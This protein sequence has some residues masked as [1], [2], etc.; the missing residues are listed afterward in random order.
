M[1][2]INRRNFIKG[3]VASL[4]AVPLA[5]S[6]KRSKSTTTVTGREGSPYNMQAHPVA[7]VYTDEMRESNKTHGFNQGYI[8]V[9]GV[10]PGMLI[11]RNKWGATWFRSKPNMVVIPTPRYAI[12]SDVAYHK[13]RG[14]WE[15]QAVTA[16]LYKVTAPYLKSTIS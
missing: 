16:P 10:E 2:K 5:Y 11:F 9:N 13:G 7:R 12:V 14:C 4:L 15:V 1:K 3:A 8:E 6:C